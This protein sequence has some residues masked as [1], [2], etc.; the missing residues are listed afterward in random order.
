[1]NTKKEN[2]KQARELEQARAEL[3]S[4]KGTLE[5]AKKGALYVMGV[6]LDHCEQAKRDLLGAATLDRATAARALLGEKLE[7]YEAC[8]WICTKAGFL[9]EG[10]NT[11]LQN[12]ATRL[13]QVGIAHVG[14]HYRRNNCGLSCAGAMLPEDVEEEV[15]DVRR[16]LRKA[17]EAAKEGTQ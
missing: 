8:G 13:Y 2:E 3:E 12:K 15:E 4:V 11:E 5:A 9:T 7:A 6:R 16:A 14:K 17:Q 10:D 1:M